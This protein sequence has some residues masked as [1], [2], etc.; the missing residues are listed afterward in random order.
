MVRL[1]TGEKLWMR[2]L[3]VVVL[4]VLSDHLKYPHRNNQ[5]GLTDL[6]IPSPD[7]QPKLCV[8]QYPIFDT[9]GNTA[10]NL[11]LFDVTMVTTVTSTVSTTYIVIIGG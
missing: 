7:P 5:K 10:Q 2:L 4:C 1:I 8:D 11:F 3:V 9:G 6:L